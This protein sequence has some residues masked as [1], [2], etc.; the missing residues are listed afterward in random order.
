VLSTEKGR[1]QVRTVS[2]DRLGD[3]LGQVPALLMLEID[4]AIRIHLEL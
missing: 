4:E 2:V 1:V 3:V